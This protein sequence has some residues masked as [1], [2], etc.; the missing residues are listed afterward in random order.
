MNIRTRG[1]VAVLGAAAL[2]IPSA[3]VA[4]PGKGKGSA[5]SDDAPAKAQKR[6][7]AKSKAKAKKVRTVTYVLKGRYDA[8][9]NLDVTGGNSHTRRAGLIGEEVELDLSKARLSVADTNGD[10]EVTIAY[11]VAGDKLVVQVKLP[12]RSPGAGPYVARKVVDQTHPRVDDEVENETEAEDKS[13]S[14]EDDSAA[15]GTGSG[16]AAGD[17]AGA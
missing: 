12:R 11:L 14:G 4:A 8:E 3:A 5:K 6:G 15:G 13:V 1:V 9:G 16:D 17:Q 10:D 7:K 2:T